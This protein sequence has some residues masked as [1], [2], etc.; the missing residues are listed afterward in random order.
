MSVAMKIIRDMKN[1]SLSEE[2]EIMA[3]LKHKN[4]VQIIGYS[5]IGL[6]PC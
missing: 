6:F 3:K 1:S 4:I 2:I 5:I